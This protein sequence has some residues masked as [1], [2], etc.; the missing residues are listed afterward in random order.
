MQRQNAICLLS[1]AVL[2]A[3]SG[4]RRPTPGTNDGGDAAPPPV[5][6][7]VETFASPLQVQA[8]DT[9]TARC[10]VREA[11][12][13]L[14]GVPIDIEVDAPINAKDIASDEV[15]FV[16]TTAG[17]LRVR[18]RTAQGDASDPEGVT[19]NVAP[20]P[21]A[22]VETKLAQAQAQAGK[23]VAVHC[24]VYDA[25][26][27]VNPDAQAAGVVA[28]SPVGVE[29]SPAHPF[30]VR[31]TQTGQYDVAC[32]LGS[33][34]DP[35]PAQ[36]EVTTGIPAATE[37]TL[38]PS[39][40]R[41]TDPVAV[42]CAVTDAYGNPIDDVETSFYLLPPTGETAESAGVT[43]AAGEFTATLAGEYRVFCNTP[44]YAAGDESPAV[45]TLHPGR[46]AAWNADLLQQTCYW[47]DARLPLSVSVYD[48][49]GNRVDPDALAD[50]SIA[51]DSTPAGAVT[52]DGQGG[53]VLTGE[54]DITLTLAPVGN[55]DPTMDPEVFDIRVDST[56]P[57]FALSPPERAARLPADAVPGGTAAGGTGSIQGEVVDATSP[58]VRFELNGEPQSPPGDSRTVPIS[59]EQDVRWGM[60]V[61]TG[62]AED[63]CGN[64]ALLS[65]SQLW[66]HAGYL[67]AATEANP[68][69]RVPEGAVAQLNQEVIDDGNRS[70]LDDL[71][72]VGEAAL[73][74]LSFNDLVA[75]G[76]VLI[77]EGNPDC[78][79]WC[80]SDL[81]T[82]GFTFSRKD[83][84]EPITV[85]GPYINY[86]EPV[87]G[88][89]R[90]EA[91][92]QDFRF[93]YR[94]DIEAC[95]VCVTL[96]P[97][98]TGTIEADWA[99]AQGVMGV[100]KTAGGDVQ[101]DVAEMTVDSASLNFSVDCADWLQGLCDW[102]TGGISDLIRDRVEQAIA[103]AVR[104][105]IPGVVEDF[106]G[107]F[108]VAQSFTL[109]EPLGMQ[110][111]M[112]FG[113]D[114]ITFCGPDAGLPRPQACGPSSPNPGYGQLS[115]ATQVFPSDPIGGFLTPERGVLHKAGD[116][117]GF[118]SSQYAFG[119]ALADELLNQLLWAVWYG[120]G[121]QLDLQDVLALAGDVA[122][123]GLAVQM[124]GE[125][126]PVIMASDGPEDIDI[127][128]G[129]L[130]VDA[131]VDIAELLGQPDASGQAI[132]VRMYVSAVLSGSVDIDPSTN[133]LSI[134]VG[135][136]PKVWVDVVSIDEP[137]YAAT[138]SEFFKGLLEQV[139]PRLLNSLVGAFPIPSFDLSAVAGLP[140]GTV[141]ELDAPSLERETYCLGDTCY[142]SREDYSVLTGSLR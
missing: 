40:A 66:S 35:S 28:E 17:Q 116:P 64:R 132:D 79:G 138:V 101:V 105:Q 109:P 139:L 76:Q 31:G 58:V 61:V 108:S 114:R 111:N 30:V 68:D 96:T 4:C 60:T 91:E 16:P 94:L 11:D 29:S 103:N 131:T 10:V 85:G 141:W 136:E 7:A 75:P 67:P 44:G 99:R 77:S 50:F 63:A 81:D 122:L 98:F 62:E 78:S 115:L 140:P 142:P 48:A 120:G 118:S 23:P 2:A 12:T 119:M 34:Q 14:P 86:L 21:A 129:D 41:P 100:D 15:R 113:I 124:F 137:A 42:G 87:N 45:L 43:R 53:W 32:Q 88:G 57:Q 125:Q 1:A 24:P 26:G 36:L 33:A 110:M 135:P 22:S 46:P 112:D 71:A 84:D 19:L 37:T 6:R 8:G 25:Y 123:P 92:L 121:L 106:L 69:A 27:N 107:G 97:T 5:P 52:S 74:Q 65:Q 104:D 128:I 59:V 117:P 82:I 56:P 72:S 47:E 13:H 9:V 134:S 127:G 18:C 83:N 130:S 49:W 3:T 54:G 80:P 39:H 51:L 90:F 89:M 70:D 102:A 126:P 133:E 38:T 73:Q 55:Y 93:P 20:G 95:G